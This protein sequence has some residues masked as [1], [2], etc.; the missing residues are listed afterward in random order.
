MSEFES[1]NIN[2]EDLSR[3][4]RMRVLGNRAVIAGIIEAQPVSP[5]PPELGPIILERTDVAQQAF[6]HVTDRGHGWTADGEYI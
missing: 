5:T 6:I 4:E 1:R 3:R 2:L